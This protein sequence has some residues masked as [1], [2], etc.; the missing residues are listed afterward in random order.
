MTKEGAVRSRKL[1]KKIWAKLP[2]LCL[3]G[4]GISLILGALGT[5]NCYWNVKRKLK[6]NHS[7]NFKIKLFS[8]LVLEM[9]YLYINIILSELAI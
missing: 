2:L 5:W 7:E 4:E 3:Q 1:K 9:R 8:D 6:G